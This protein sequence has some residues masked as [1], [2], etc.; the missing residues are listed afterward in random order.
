M[1]CHVSVTCKLRIAV[2]LLAALGAGPLS[3]RAGIDLPGGYSLPAPPVQI[4]SPP[5]QLPPVRL[6]NASDIGRAG[7][8]FDRQRLEAQW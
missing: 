7:A 1:R 8:D 3:A 4:P 6:P 5:I 2:V